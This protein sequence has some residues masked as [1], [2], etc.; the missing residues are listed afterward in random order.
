MPDLDEQ[1]LTVNSSDEPRTQRFLLPDI[2][3]CGHVVAHVDALSNIR[4]N[5]SSMMVYI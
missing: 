4:S 1:L 2:R 5:L 3:L